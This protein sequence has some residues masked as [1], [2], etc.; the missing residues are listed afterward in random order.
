MLSEVEDKTAVGLVVAGYVGLVIHGFVTMGAEQAFLI[1]IIFCNF[2]VAQR[3]CG[4]SRGFRNGCD[5]ANI[6]RRLSISSSETCWN[7]GL[8]DSHFGHPSVWWAT[9]SH[10]VLR[11]T[12]L[13]L[14]A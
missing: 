13:V 1:L 7:H 11:S 14:R 6:V 2:H 4:N 12:L 10:S 5:D 8:D 9:V 3:R